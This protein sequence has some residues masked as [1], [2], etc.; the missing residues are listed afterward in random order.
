M[1]RRPAPGPARRKPAQ[2]RAA[3]PPVASQPPRIIGG[4][5]KGRRLPFIPDGRTRPMKDRVREVLFDLVGPAVRG[6]LAID[7]F[8]GSG[9]IGFEAV[10]RG[11]VAAVLAERHFPTADLLRKTAVDLGI[12]DR[13][14]VRPGDVLLWARRMPEL[15]DAMPWVVFFSPPWAMFHDQPAALLD[16]ISCFLERSPPGSRLVVEADD[17]FDPALL[18]R[19][20]TW[21]QRRLSPAV[22]YLHTV[23]GD[24]SGLGP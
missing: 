14:Q 1:P 20:D 19:A 13:V 11:A 17:R 24:A 16:L 2:G 8:A 18:P 4:E 7:L 5:L 21:S 22:L 10:S 9:A 6:S 23:G 3:D 15:D 12:A